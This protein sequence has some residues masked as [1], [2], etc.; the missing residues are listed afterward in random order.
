[1]AADPIV[2]YADGGNQVTYLVRHRK[3]K[4]F[5][6]YNLRKNTQTFIE[7]RLCIVPPVVERVYTGGMGS[8]ISRVLRIKETNHSSRSKEGLEVLLQR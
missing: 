4:T 1:M 3:G 7:R 2:G 6:W 5:I 8:I